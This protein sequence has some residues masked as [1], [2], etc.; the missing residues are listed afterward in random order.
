MEKKILQQD[1]R[2][3]E[4]KEA[5]RLFLQQKRKREEEARALLTAVEMKRKKVD[6]TPLL[7]SSPGT[8]ATH[9]SKRRKMGGPQMNR[10]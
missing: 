9:I 3:E 8:I 10:T 2:M 1:Q 7:F 6:Q 5:H 4:E